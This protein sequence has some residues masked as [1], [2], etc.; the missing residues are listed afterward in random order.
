M[1]A[2]HV[3]PG[4]AAR[5]DITAIATVAVMFLATLLAVALLLLLQSLRS[6]YA[7]P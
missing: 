3:V 6:R 4:W 5:P 7:R 2:S 1:L